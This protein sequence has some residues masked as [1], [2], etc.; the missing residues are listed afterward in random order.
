MLCSTF[1][2]LK[3]KSTIYERNING[4]QLW[5]DSNE[6]DLGLLFSSNSKFNKHVDL[7]AKKAN[8]KLGIIA[9]VFETRGTKSMLEC[10]NF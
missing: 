1:W 5:S 8:Q 10:S 2:T 9:K 6:K 3:Y 4:T 7:I